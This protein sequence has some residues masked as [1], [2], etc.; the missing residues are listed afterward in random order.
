[1]TSQALAC[2]GVISSIV[3]NCDL[4][5]LSD[6]IQQAVPATRAILN[7]GAGQFPQM[8]AAF[9]QFVPP[10]GQGPF[11]PQTPPIQMG[12]ACLTQTGFHPLNFAMP[13]GATCSGVNQFG[14]YEVGSVR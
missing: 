14:V 4:D 5:K 8:P 6:S 2:S 13:V 9:P 10:G 3:G 1:M 7:P 12:G 11:F